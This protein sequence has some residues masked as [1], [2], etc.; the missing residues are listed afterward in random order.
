MSNDSQEIECPYHIHKLKLTH[1]TLAY[2]NVCQKY[3]KNN[4]SFVCKQC[5]FDLCEECLKKSEE[6]KN[7]SLEVLEKLM[8]A[9]QNIS[10]S[11]SMINFIKQRSDIQFSSPS[12]HNSLVCSYPSFYLYEEHN[13]KE[14]N[15]LT[16]TRSY[17]NKNGQ[18]V[19]FFNS[20]KSKELIQICKKCCDEYFVNHHLSLKINQYYPKLKAL[21]SQNNCFSYA[22][23]VARETSSS[24]MF[25]ASYGLLKKT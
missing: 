25:G 20:T 5:D 1:R 17:T 8:L 7:L 11:E 2:C 9:Y 24:I 12:L 18:Y 19:Y 3:I 22:D 10:E 13:Q 15:L 23:S 4:N 16:A 21:Q 14:G 6:M